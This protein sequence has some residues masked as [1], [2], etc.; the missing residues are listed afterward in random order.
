MA[1][2]FLLTGLSGAGKTTLAEAVC[3]DLRKLQPCV[4]L[5]G[6]ELRKSLCRDLG[7]SPQDREE[8]IRRCGEI[9]KILSRQGITVIMAVIAPYQKIRDNLKEIIGADNLHVIHVDCPLDICIERD[10][11]NNYKKALQGQL[12]NYTGIADA[13]EAPVQPDLRLQTSQESQDAS[14]AKLLR[15]IESKI[16]A[17]EKQLESGQ[18]HSL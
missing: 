5:D 15:F 7:F 4:L 12:K 10:P 18:G 17:Q 3:R 9:A 13:Y 6:D 14:A 1:Q 2:V 11:K 16:L 8:N